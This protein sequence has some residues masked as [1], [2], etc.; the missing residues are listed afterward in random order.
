MYV[1]PNPYL[2]LVIHS[3]EERVHQQIPYV[4][5][6]VV[7]LQDYYLELSSGLLRETLSPGV[8][9]DPI[10][11][12]ALINGLNIR[13]CETSPGKLCDNSSAALSMFDLVPNE[14]HRLRL[15]NVGAFAWFEVGLDEHSLPIT[16]VDGTDV[17]PS[18]VDQLHIAPAQRYS[19][20]VT[21]NHTSRESFWLRAR[22]ITHCFTEPEKPGNGMDE[23]RAIIQ[24]KKKGTPAT[25]KKPPNPSSDRGSGF[26][27]QCFDMNRTIF[28]PM[29]TIAPPAKPD[30]TYH[31]R[32]N[33]QIG[34]WRLERGFFNTSTF[35]PSLRSP[36]LH[37]AI[38]GL[39]SQNI[40]F[41][42]I[43][44]GINSEA[45]HLPTELVIQHEGSPVIDLI[46]QNFD[47]NAHPLHL[48]GHKFWVLGQGHAYFPG[49]EKLDID[50]IN[51]I[52]RDTAA[53]EGFGWMLIR[54]VA[55]N[56]GM[57]AFHCHMAW[58]SEAGLLMQFLSRSEVVAGWEIPEASKRL[59]EVDVRTLEKGAAPK[60]DIW[61]GFG[62]G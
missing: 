44:S 59:C 20:I 58:H 26:A 27:V 40:S 17:M 41:T 6:R 54:F 8:E 39:S 28:N 12:G 24:Y 43:S 21:A 3:R 13:N 33:I 9:G 19:V 53:V 7:M 2:A 29:P 38:E 37:R 4:T 62:I 61:Y 56:P 30:H 48:H 1:K 22:M 35:R 14:S 25:A 31:L 15:L 51:P 55:D 10:P 18:Y 45:F 52:R 34:D 49:Y 5:D 47:E 42:N 60:D 36:S 23:V 16:E 32:A 11:D 50:L 46:I 57:W